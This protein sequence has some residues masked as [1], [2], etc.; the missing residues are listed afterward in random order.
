MNTFVISR[1]PIQFTNYDS[2]MYYEYWNGDD[3]WGDYSYCRH[4]ESKDEAISI[5]SSLAQH[6]EYLYFVEE[7]DEDGFVLM[8]YEV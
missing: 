1:K 6:I 7:I 4:Y 2:P 5:A 8:E 3:P